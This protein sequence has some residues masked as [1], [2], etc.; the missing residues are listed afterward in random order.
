MAYHKQDLYR[1]FI[2]DGWIIALIGASAMIARLMSTNNN[3]TFVSQLR[4]VVCSAFLTASAWLLLEG[5]DIPS[6]YKAVSYGLIG[7]FSPELIQMIF[8]WLKKI[9]DRPTI[10][11]PWISKK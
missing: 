3:G 6:L 4:K 2:E 7:L 10:L 8:V 11:I 9:K 1:S 5:A